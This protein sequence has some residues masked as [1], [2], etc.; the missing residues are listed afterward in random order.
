MAD[1][2]RSPLWMV[3]QEPR[4]NDFVA[5]LTSYLDDLRARP[6]APHQ[7][8]FSRARVAEV[9]AA[10]SNMIL[11]GEATLHRL[12]GL[13][14]SQIFG[15]WQ[16]SSVVVGEVDST[17]E[18]FVLSQSLAY[19]E[20]FAT[21]DLDLGTRQLA[22]LRFLD[23]NGWSRASLVANF[24]EY[25]PTEPNSWRAHKLISRIKAEEEIW[26]KVVDEIFDLDGLISRDKQMSHLSQYVKDVFGLKLVVG[27]TADVQPLNQLLLDH[28]WDGERL[29]LLETKDYMTQDGRKASGWAALKSVVRWSG[30]TFEIQIQPLRNYL[31][32][33]E[34]LTKESH[35]GF[36]VRRE[37]VRDDVAARVPLFGFYR[38][39]LKW[40][41][42]GAIKEDEVPQ[43][44]GVAIRLTD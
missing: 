39:L 7:L 4:L 19:E 34:Y 17:R 14:C 33:Q 27:T 2:E 20:L 26:N 35:A 43:F 8:T 5:Y 30:R 44:P 13:L 12:G 1:L 29:E 32:E 40:L 24:V 37:A 15:A 25:Q 23:A 42:V 6:A 11:R 31:K 21:S 22:K 3:T 38:A 16:M 10:F 28:P 36:K 18:R 41:F 9:R